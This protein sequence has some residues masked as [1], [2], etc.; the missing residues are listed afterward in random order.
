MEHE[1]A[2]GRWIPIA[3]YYLAT[4]VGLT[5]VLVGTIG[6]LQ[7][8]ISVAV[9]QVSEDVRFSSPEF[10]PDQKAV[11]STPAQRERFESDR[12]EARVR[13]IK[14]ARLGGIGDAL[15][16]LVAALVGAPVFFWHLRQARRR[17]PHHPEVAGDS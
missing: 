3:Y 12:K 17:D 2:K 8:L 4:V 1:P 13:A 6:G 15:R 10:P 7:G 5:I 11:V 16:G 14:D 9:P